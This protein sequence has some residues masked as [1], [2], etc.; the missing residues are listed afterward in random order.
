MYSAHTLQSDSITIK[1]KE[2]QTTNSFLSCALGV[3]HLHKDFVDVREHKNELDRFIAQAYLKQ[4]IEGLILKATQWL[5]SPL[6]TR[7]KRGSW[8]VEL[9]SDKDVDQHPEYKAYRLLHATIGDA[10][11]MRLHLQALELVAAQSR[12]IRSMCKKAT[13]TESIL[14][15]FAEEI[16]SYVNLLGKDQCIIATG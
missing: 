13:I 3:L 8:L 5:V 14:E 2:L 15:N 1:A 7:Q 10:P 4:V 12:N 16:S 11:I 6:P 9:I